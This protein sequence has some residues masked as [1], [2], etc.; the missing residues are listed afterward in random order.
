M[1]D[2]CPF[3]TVASDLGTPSPFCDLFSASEWQ[4]YDYYQTLGKYYGFG[5]G[6]PL[7][8]TQGVGYVNELIARMTGK[9]VVDQ[10]SVNHTLDDNPDTFPLGKTLYADF[11]HD[12]G[13]TAVFSAL[14]LYNSTPPLSQTKIMS[15]DQT[16]G[17]SAAWTVPFAAR[18]VIEK[19]Q[20]DGEEDESVR[21]LIN[22]RVLPLESCGADTMGRC[23][24]HDFLRSLS[25]AQGGGHWGECSVDG[26]ILPSLDDGDQDEVGTSR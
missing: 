21:V 18:A 4:Q 3:N 7:G 11:G 12:N 6:N 17:Y 23:S 24:I 19:M 15:I 20:C 10:T 2:L 1:M 14:G 13:L 25:F 8:P 26:K 16:K 9:P 5:P 22:G